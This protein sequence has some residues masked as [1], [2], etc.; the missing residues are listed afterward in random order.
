MS[1]PCNSLFL[2]LCLRAIDPNRG[3]IIL[4]CGSHQ[5]SW[6]L[7]DP[8]YG[9]RLET[10]LQSTLH[11]DAFVFLW[12]ILNVI[13]S[14]QFWIYYL[15]SMVSLEFCSYI[16]VL[17]LLNSQFLQLENIKQCVLRTLGLSRL[18]IHLTLLTS[19]VR[20]I[21]A[22]MRHLFKVFALMKHCTPASVA[23]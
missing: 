1:G 13:S 23:Q 5:A 9:N 22:F 4:S 16:S 2:V 11:Q 18:F 6:G 12:H 10:L 21:Q 8:T 14:R 20:T 19:L 3:Q 15:Y 17:S 7:K